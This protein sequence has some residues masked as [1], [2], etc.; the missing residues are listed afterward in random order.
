LDGSTSV[1]IT[2]LVA[3]HHAVVFRA[4]FRLSGSNADA[5]DLTQQTF[6]AAHRSLGQ[7]REE[8]AALGWLM[9][10]L[11]SCF[12]KECRKRRPMAADD[13]NIDLNLYAEEIP[14]D[15]EID[16]E[17][18][19]SALNELSAESRSMLTMFYF[20]ELSYREIAAATDIP[21]GTVMSRLSRAKEQL[22]RKLSD[23]V[24]DRENSETDAVSSPTENRSGKNATGKPLAPVADE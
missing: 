17:R 15:N 1:D 22:R 12:L 14:A 7:L 13:C 18:L 4:A 19:Q 5:E 21:L 9:A 3:E 6:L 20:E 16:P 11:R 2:R 10:I 8:R 24:S 23:N